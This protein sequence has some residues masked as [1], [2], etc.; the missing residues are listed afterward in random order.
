MRRSLLESLILRATRGYARLWHRWSS[1]GK[2]WIPA[3]GPAIVVANHTC[4]AD[5]MFLMAGSPRLLAFAVTRE[6][7]DVHPVVR[8]LLDFAHCVPVTRHGRDV[9]AA[10]Q[11]LQRLA[12]GQV[13]G[14][15]PEGGL[16]GVARC[17]L[18]TARHGAAYLALKTRAPVYPAYIAGGPRT[19]RLLNSWLL[20]T[21]RAVRVFFGPSV[22]LSAWY[23]QPPTRRRLEEVS[24]YLAACI[25]SLRPEHEQKERRY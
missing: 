12:D 15:F 1:R 14:I 24:Q 9:S 4:S 17:R 5:P 25:L 3:T 7:F 16:S 6:H 10:R 23:G 20:P 18:C 19:D 21:P 2:R 11:L 8:R 13:V 22:D